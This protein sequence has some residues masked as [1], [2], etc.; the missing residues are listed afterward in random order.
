MLNCKQASQLV[1]QSLDRP[2]LWSERLQLKLHLFICNPCRRFKQQLKLFAAA[3]HLRN[4]MI[5]NDQDIKLPLEVKNRILQA[6][7][8]G[9]MQNN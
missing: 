5:E 4:R 3:I 2:L 1:S 8:A 9:F 7:D 6:K